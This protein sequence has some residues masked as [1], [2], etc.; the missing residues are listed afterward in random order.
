M[1]SDLAR[2]KAA[3][4]ADL[5]RAARAARKETRQRAHVDRLVRW[6]KRLERWR[7]ALDHGT[8]LMKAIA[9]IMV[10]VSAV[11]TAYAKLSDYIDARRAPAAELP[12][13]TGIASTAL[14]RVPEPTPPKR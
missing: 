1:A 9:G 2:L 10:A 4:R 13:P 3:E 6:R 11:L 14:D 8:A 12:A 5:K 7:S